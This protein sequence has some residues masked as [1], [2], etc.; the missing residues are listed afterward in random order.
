M[1]SHIGSDFEEFLAEQGMSGDVSSAASVRLQNEIIRN[2]IL[3]S[4]MKARGVRFLPAQVIKSAMRKHCM[5][6]PRST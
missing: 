6:L 4:E 1:Q 2:Q 5:S 3:I